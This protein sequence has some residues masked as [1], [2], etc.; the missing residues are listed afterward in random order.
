MSKLY[1]RFYIFLLTAIVITSVIILIKQGYSYYTLN[2]EERFYNDLH[3][4]LK[5]S[6]SW[7]HGLGII[8]SFLILSGVIIYMLRKR[9]RGLSQLGKMKHWLEFHIF[10][11]TLGAILV[12]FHTSFK[13]GGIVAISFWSMVAVVI[14][15][16]IG[17]YIYLQIPRT[18]E[19]R[20]LSLNELDNN[21]TMILKQLQEKYGV[22]DDLLTNL[23]TLID[24]R[25]NVNK[26]I[27]TT[28][29][30]RKIKI[31]RSVNSLLEKQNFGKANRKIIKQLI[32]EELKLS[33]KIARLETMKNLFQYWHVAHLPFAFIMLFIMI[34]HVVITILF[35]YKWIF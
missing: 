18:I 19:G 13:F 9:I 8:G 25:S 6:G 17:R 22:N 23:M 29:I 11:C 1:H 3:N 20:E 33:G 28:S 32:S 4:K 10:L 27:L 5:P 24:R 2:I 26:R 14:S 7:G 34:I 31:N 21:K 12:L 16:I 30:A 35:G 15:G